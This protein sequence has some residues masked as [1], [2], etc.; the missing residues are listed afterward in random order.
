[1][2]TIQLRKVLVLLSKCCTFMPHLITVQCRVRFFSFLFALINRLA[3]KRSA[4]RRHHHYHHQQQCLFR[5]S[6]CACSIA[7]LF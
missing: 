6:V 2:F 5:F 3:H 1:M 7:L 4:A